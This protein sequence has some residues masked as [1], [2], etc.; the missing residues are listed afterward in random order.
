MLRNFG[1]IVFVNS[2]IIIVIDFAKGKLYSIALA[3]YYQ[4][5]AAYMKGCPRSAIQIL[6]P[7]TMLLFMLITA[8]A[9]VF[10]QDKTVSGNVTD[11]ATGQP[12]AG[13]SVRVVGSNNGV[14][15]NNKGAF[16]LTV[17]EN[18]TIEISNVGYGAVSVAPGFSGP[19]QIQLASTNTQLSDVVVIAYGTQRKK[20]I[21]GSVAVV[22]M[23]AMNSIPTGSAAQALQGQAAGVNIISSGVPGGRNDIFVRGVTSFGNTQPLV[24]VDGVQSDLNNLNMNDIESM[25]VLK[26]AG[27][28]SIYGV[29]GSNGVILIT[30][31]KGKMGAPQVSY[32]GYYG[33]Q[34]PLPGNVWNLLT[35]QENAAYVMELNPTSALYQNGIPDYTYKG[36]LGG[37][38]AMAGDPAV[39]PSKYV[40]DAANPANNYQI[41]KMNKSGTDFFHAIFKTAPMQSHNITASGATDKSSYLFSLGYLNQQGTLIETYLKRYSVRVN[42]EYKFTKNIRVGENAFFFYKQNPGFSNQSSENAITYTYRDLPLLPIYDIMGN[43]AGT[44]AGPELGDASNPVA[45]QDR[46][47]NNKL[48]TWD[49]VGNVYGEADFLRHFTFRTSFGGTID[50]SYNYNIGYTAYENIEHHTEN[51]SFSETAGYNS[52]YTWT[53]TLHYKNTFGR[54]KVDVIGGTEAIRNYGRSLTGG[55]TNF[56]SLEP[57]YLILPNGTANIT[58]SSSAYLNTLFSLFGRVDYA[59][60]DKYLVGATVRRDGSSV[61]GSDKR[62]GVFPSFSLGWRLSDEG[63]MKGIGFINDLKLKGSYGILGSQANVDPNNA[64]TLYNSG[65]A[66]SYYDITGSSSSA[67]QGFRQSR[68]GNSATGWEQDKISNFGVEA[69]VLNNRL[70]VSVERYKKS[71]NGLLFPLPLPSSAGNATPPTVNIGDIANKGWDISATYRGEITSDLHFNIGANITTYKNEVVKIP[72]PGYFDVPFTSSLIGSLVRNQEGHPVGSF[73]G[74]QVERLFRDADDVSKS[75]AQTDAA[76]GRFKYK[77]V[78]GDGQITPDDR[79]F[80]GNPNPK[81]TYGL[82]LSLTFKNFDLAGIFYG[83]QGNDVLNMTRYYTDFY[84]TSNG[85]LAKSNV[86]K[87]AWTP[88]NLNAKVPLREFSGSF[89][90]NGSFNSYYKENG[91]FLKMRS[92]IIGYTVSPG[93]L[94]NFRIS[95]LRVYL[96]SANLFTITKYSGLDPELG[97]LLSGSQ[98]SSAFGVDFANYP[99]NQRS[100]LLGANITF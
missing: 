37:G 84:S 76:P 35:P 87:D 41:Q 15:T 59:Y 9:V 29:R 91:S 56:F 93:V 53:N 88:Q 21:T 69:T 95:N 79:T 4:T 17:G 80:I 63:F 99:N 45:V 19:M 30:T 33:I 77:D 42:T 66:T 92:L 48:N 2:H 23:K 74:Y 24:I 10:G 39:D 98:S 12:I 70:Y 86:V 26:D 54:H 18:A 75:P 62:Y 57:N 46:T 61:F 55:A 96:Q 27:A 65:F 25:Q 83:S 1:Y 40:F 82:N 34:N 3:S 64:Y 43:Y 60:D 58:N 72:D 11:S 71:I 31:K 52:S 7:K 97:G 22:D 36:P 16:S 38:V 67:Q 6:F 49:I 73:F 28:A 51:N 44:F 8:A 14:S 20:D 85:G 68:V 90:S 94:R 50:N 78:N 5:K 89:S 13:A 32:N 81:F 100:F 47:K